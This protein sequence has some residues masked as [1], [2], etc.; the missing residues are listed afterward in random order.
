MI[1]IIAVFCILV[2]LVSFIRAKSILNP[3]TVFYSVWG[4]LVPVSGLGFYNMYVPS[5]ETYFIIF[6]GL[7]GYFLG[8]ILGNRVQFKIG[9]LGSRKYNGEEAIINYR[10]LYVLCGISMIYFAYMAT[11]VLPILLSGRGLAYIRSLAVDDERNELRSSVL[12]I[13]IKNFIATPTVYLSIAILPIEIFRGK[14]DKVFLTLVIAMM[15]FW[16]LSTGGRSI[17][18]WEAVYFVVVYIYQREQKK[19]D[20]RRKIRTRTKVIIFIVLAILFYFL[21]ITTLSRKGQD[22]D[23]FRQICIYFVAPVEFFETWVGKVKSAYS[24]YYSLGFSSFYGIA[25]PFILV[26]RRLGF[27]RANDSFFSVARELSFNAL[28]EVVSIGDGFNMNA[29]AT[30]FF[31]P[32]IDGRL[33]GVFIILGIFGYYNSFIYRRLR[34]RNDNRYLLFY[35]LAFQKILFSMVR[36]YYTQPAQ[37]ICFFFSFF[38]IKYASQKLSGRHS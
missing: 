19:L 7:I 24:D 33:I 5:E 26:I 10:L 28:Q 29:F 20:K 17:I 13:S 9:K 3:M 1:W 14:K 23:L 11:R 32:Y 25:Y 4:I 6:I 31:Q 37:S 36:F 2:G 12:Q 21:L 16:V 15:V 27:I 8:C 38:A 35:L 30:V 18:L 34:K 22:V